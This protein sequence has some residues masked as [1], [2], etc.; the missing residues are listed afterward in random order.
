MKMHAQ[1]RRIAA[2]HFRL[3]RILRRHPARKHRLLRLKTRAQRRPQKS[4]PTLYA[5]KWPHKRR[6]QQGPLQ[7][8]LP[9][10]SANAPAAASRTARRRQIDGHGGTPQGLSAIESEQP[11]AGQ[12]QTSSSTSSREPTIN[13]EPPVRNAVNPAPPALNP[14]TSLQNHVTRS[15]CATHP[16]L[17]NPPSTP[18]RFT[19]RSASLRCLFPFLSSYQQCSIRPPPLVPFWEP[20]SN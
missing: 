5:T 16:I 10:R 3:R 20:D 7:H 4:P 1:L 17:S 6:R 14:C 2:A 18:P 11:L 19:A 9:S 8:A 15:F 13:P 12:G